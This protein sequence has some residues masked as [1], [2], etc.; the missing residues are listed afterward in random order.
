LRRPRTL[1]AGIATSRWAEDPSGRVQTDVFAA[2]LAASKILSTFFPYASIEGE[3]VVA[4]VHSA[5]KTPWYEK[6][7]EKVIIRARFFFIVFFMITDIL[8]FLRDN[9]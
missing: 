5:A 8:I 4:R 6:R 1:C 7:N 3:G 9:P 2:F